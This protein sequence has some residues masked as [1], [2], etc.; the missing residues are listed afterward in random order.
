M[1]L[2]GTDGD[3]AVGRD[4]AQQ[5]AAQALATDFGD[6]AARAQDAPSLLLA[7]WIFVPLLV[8]CL[9]RSRLPLYLLP[10]F[11]P[12]ALLIAQRRKADGRG[13]PRWPRLLVWFGLLLAALTA[14]FSL[15]VGAGV[16]G[17]LG[18]VG[19][20]EIALAHLLAFTATFMQMMVTC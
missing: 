3:G 16:L 15:A 1:I 12:L 6:D 17:A 19:A 5:A 2:V 10:L 8:F 20:G 11:V 18:L 7:L 9:A 13:M 4:A 14:G